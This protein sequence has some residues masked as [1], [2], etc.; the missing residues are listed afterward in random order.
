MGGKSRLGKYIAKAIMDNTP[1]GVRFI[2]EPFCGGFGCTRAL[3]KLAPMYCTDIN[4]SVISLAKAVQ[5]GWCPPEELTEEEY[6]AARNLPDDDPMK[7]FVG[8]GCSFGGKW[9]GG[10]ARNAKGTNHCA[11]ARRSLLKDFEHADRI[12]FDC[13]SFF[14]VKPRTASGPGCVIYCDPPYRGTT[15]YTHAKEFD[16]DLFW[17]LCERWAD[18]GW[19]VYI[20]EFSTLSSRAVVVWEKQRTLTLRRAENKPVTEKLYKIVTDKMDF[21]WKE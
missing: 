12:I 18:C 19:H 20:S 21:E 6:A 11:G 9:F 2:W 7:A 10:F 16:H 13:L 3:S 15:K 4:L 8:F 14:D 5:A 17:R 1:G